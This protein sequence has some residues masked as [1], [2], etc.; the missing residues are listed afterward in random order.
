MAPKTLTE[1]A[2]NQ[3]SESVPAGTEVVRVRIHP[4]ISYSLSVSASGRIDLP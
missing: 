1:P 4:Q 2:Q 3:V